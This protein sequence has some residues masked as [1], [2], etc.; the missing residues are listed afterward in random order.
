MINNDAAF[1]DCH[2]VQ[3]APDVHEHGP[4]NLYLLRVPVD[5]GDLLLS[6]TPQSPLQIGNWVFGAT[7]RSAS[8]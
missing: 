3:H 6:E 2:V 8:R 5:T 1:I 7:F 4:I